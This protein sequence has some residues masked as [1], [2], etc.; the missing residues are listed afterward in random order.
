MKVAVSEEVG[1]SESPKLELEICTDGGHDPNPGAGGYG[2]V[3]LH[4]RKRAEAS[5]GFQSAW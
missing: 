1:M 3:V 5:G 2:V 4:P